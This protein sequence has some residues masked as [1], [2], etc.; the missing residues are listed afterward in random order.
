M[1]P[2]RKDYLTFIQE[3]H[4]QNTG[5]SRQDVLNTL[6]EIQAA[7]QK[8]GDTAL[9]HYTKKFDNAELTSEKGSVSVL[10]VN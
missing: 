10:N 6:S 9:C 3:T 5:K 1:I 2:I 8:S 4:S 7:I